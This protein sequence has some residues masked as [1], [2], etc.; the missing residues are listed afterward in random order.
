MIGID[1]AIKRRSSMTN[2]IQPF[3]GF[4]V[5][6]VRVDPPVLLAPM[7]DVTS[8]PFRLIAKRIGKPGLMFPE[9]ISAMAVHYN[10]QKTIRQTRA[11]PAERPLAIQIFGPKPEVIAEAAVL[12]DE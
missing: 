5:G 1:S 7:E 2:E 3:R 6:P 11:H 12:A 8:L 9:F 10:A 4:N